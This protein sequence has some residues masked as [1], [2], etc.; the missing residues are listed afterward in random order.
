MAADDHRRLVR[1]TMIRSAGATGF[2]GLLYALLPVGG[3][4]VGS[5]VVAIAGGLVA[6]G[7]VVLVRV[8]KIVEDPSPTVR[9]AEALFLV[10]PFFVAVFA[11]GYLS[12]SL[13][14][15]QAFSEPLDRIDALYFTLS[16]LSTVG[17][18]DIAA[19]DELARLLVTAQMILDLTL[20]V[21]LIRVVTAAARKGAQRRDQSAPSVRPG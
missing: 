15:P 19:I 16:I 1:I 9:A 5:S 3:T 7:M 21:A 12:L 17:F 14:D 6:L 4:T 11:C 2:I 20:L 18:G 13:A 10:V 8:P